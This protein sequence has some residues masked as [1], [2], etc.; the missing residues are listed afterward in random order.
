MSGPACGT[1]GQS[2]KPCCLQGCACEPCPCAVLTRV[3]AF[4][5]ASFTEGLS[6]FLAAN[7]TPEPVVGAVRFRPVEV[8]AP[9]V[10]EAPPQAHPDQLALDLWPVCVCGEAL[11]RYSEQ[12]AGRHAHCLEVTP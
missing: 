12:V 6:E 7:D 10:A 2:V 9:Y 5:S 4:A 1:C 8:S 11:E 3:Q